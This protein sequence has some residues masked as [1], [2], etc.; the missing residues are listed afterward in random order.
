M[1]QPHA[2]GAQAAQREVAIIRR[3]VAAEVLARRLGRLEH[4][5]VAHEMMPIIASEWPTM[6]LVPAWIDR[7]QPWS[8]GLK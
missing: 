3:G 5:A 4:R 6:Y 7:S 1:A 8:N 2:H